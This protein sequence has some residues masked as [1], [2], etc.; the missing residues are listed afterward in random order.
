MVELMMRRR[1]LMAA[2]GG[3]IPPEP[4][5]NGWELAYSY[6]S[7]ATWTA[8]WDGWFR[9]TSIGAGGAGATGGAFYAVRRKVAGS[10]GGGGGS[11]GCS[12]SVLYCKAGD[13]LSITY[14]G[15]AKAA[16][17]IG[18]EAITV[19]ASAGG[20]GKPGDVGSYT[21]IPSGG[22]GGAAGGANSGNKFNLPGN[23]GGKGADGYVATLDSGRYTPSTTPNGGTGGTSVASHNA[24]FA[25]K[26]AGGAGGRGGYRVD[27]Y[28]WYDDPVSGSAGN[29]GGV[30]IEKE[31]GRTS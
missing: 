27:S 15:S 11:G 1:A 13:T 20:T 29:P 24:A 22:N 26:G 5:D 16:G 21:T 4:G 7:N 17:T 9:I 10:G 2:L 12:V 3:G 19:Y 25:G 6:T 18:G 31:K 28:H 14:N 8:P 23:A 30:F